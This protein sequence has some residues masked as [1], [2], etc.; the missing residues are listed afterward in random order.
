[1]IHGVFNF[2]RCIISVDSSSLIFL[3]DNIQFINTTIIF[4]FNQTFQEDTEIVLII[5]SQSFS[6]WPIVQLNSP[7]TGCFTQKS[8]AKSL[9]LLFTLSCSSPTSSSPS[10]STSSLP[11]YL[12]ALVG[13]VCGGILVISIIIGVIV[14][15]R[16]Q[17]KMKKEIRDLKN[18]AKSTQ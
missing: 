10:P 6:S 7:P 13:G 18:K 3:Y 4:N 15:K 16:K 2:T 9:S 1:M 5:S 17:I 12:P 14:T 11:S 8:N